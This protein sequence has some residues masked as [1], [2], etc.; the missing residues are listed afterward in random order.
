MKTNPK[1]IFYIVLATIIML[2]PVLQGCN[3]DDEYYNYDCTN[4]YTLAK[5]LI[6]PGENDSFYFY[7][8]E[9]LRLENVEF[10][11]SDDPLPQRINL[12]VD[13]F[14]CSDARYSDIVFV[15]QEFNTFD[16]IQV[17][18]SKC[19]LPHINPF[20]GED[21]V[22]FTTSFIAIKNVYSDSTENGKQ[23]YTSK[24]ISKIPLSAFTKANL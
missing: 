16:S 21:Y 1:F 2:F 20:W 17:D 19:V 7:K 18:R 4:T 10:T 3:S 11:S 9:N 6:L 22:Y 23:I 5:S 15:S 12:S 13:V 8:K 24:H 14:C